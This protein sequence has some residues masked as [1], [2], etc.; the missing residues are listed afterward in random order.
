LRN[1]RYEPVPFA[2]SK[3]SNAY[4]TTQNNT[5]KRK[6]EKADNVQTFSEIDAARGLLGRF[7]GSYVM[8]IIKNYMLL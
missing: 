3:V 7:S 1:T 4:N 8:D 5:E 2:I 6:I